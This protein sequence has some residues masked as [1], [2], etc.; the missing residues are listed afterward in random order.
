MEFTFHNSY[1][2]LERVSSTVIFW[3]ELTCWCKSYPNKATLL[4]GWSHHYKNYTVVITIWLTVMKYPYLKW[5]WNFYFL[6]QELLTLPEHLSSPPIFGWFRV[7]HFLI[8]LCCPIMCTFWVP[9]YDVHYDFRIIM[10]F[11]S[12]L[13]P[14]VFRRDKKIQNG[15]RCHG[16]QGT[17]WPPK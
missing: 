16:N 2:I 10:M 3:T 1:V 12:S 11:G 4:L 7:V 5:Q 14:V 8:F 6:K 13:P 15:G 17:K 9:C